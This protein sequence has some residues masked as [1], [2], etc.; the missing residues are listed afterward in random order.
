MP[1]HLPLRFAPPEVA[2]AK[3]LQI[4]GVDRPIMALP[5]RASPGFHEAIV[6]R[7]IVPDRV[8]PAGATGAEVRI[9]LQY[10]LIDVGQDELL[11]G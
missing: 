8:P 6:Q 4:G 1:S 7:E 5:V 11:L 10:V 9:V 3:I 2:T